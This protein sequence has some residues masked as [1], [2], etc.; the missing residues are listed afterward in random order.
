MRG[1]DLNHLW[2][3]SPPCHLEIDLLLL[4]QMND[5]IGN[6]HTGI[7]G[8]E[9][10][11][12]GQF[13]G[14]GGGDGC[15]GGNASFTLAIALERCALTGRASGQWLRGQGADGIA[16]NRIGSNLTFLLLFVLLLF[17]VLVLLVLVLVLL[18]PESIGVG[19]DDNGSAKAQTPIP[20]PFLLHAGMRRVVGGNGSGL[21]KVK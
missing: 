2:S 15:R 11:F 19:F 1:N 14:G 10:D 6:L 8:E 3:N 7:S 20:L 9:G 12:L 4:V 13:R 5:A 16:H 18:Q 21:Y 17:L